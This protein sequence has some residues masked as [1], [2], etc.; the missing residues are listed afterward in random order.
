MSKSRDRKIRYIVEAIASTHRHFDWLK[1]SKPERI[2]AADVYLDHMITNRTDIFWH[3]GF[4]HFL[5]AL[6]FESYLSH[7]LFL[8]ASGISSGCGYFPMTTAPFVSAI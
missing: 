1:V 2:C 7:I 6:L 5:F 3:I 8:K 4:P